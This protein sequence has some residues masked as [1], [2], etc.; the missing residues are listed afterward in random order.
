M[1]RVTQI[2]ASGTIPEDAVVLHYDELDDNFRHCFPSL[3]ERAPFEAAA[4]ESDRGDDVYVKFTD[5]YRISC[6]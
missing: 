5:Y 2:E 6:R 4:P 3:V 1:G